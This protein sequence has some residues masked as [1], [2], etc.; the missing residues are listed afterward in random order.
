MDWGKTY[1]DI[2]GVKPDSSS[3]EIKTA[4]RELA[5]AYHPDTTAY[6]S[7]KHAENKFKK[8]N[9]AYE[10]LSDQKKRLE[11]DEQLF[12]RYQDAEADAESVGGNWRR[13][14]L[15]DLPDY[16]GV[17]RPV[18][19]EMYLS[20]DEW[21]N[22]ITKT[23]EIPVI[24]VCP[25]CK[26]TGRTGTRTCQ[27]C[28]GSTTQTKNVSIE[29]NVPSMVRKGIKI[30][31]FG[32]INKNGD[33]GIFPCDLFL[34][35][36]LTRSYETSRS[37]SVNRDYYQE[38]NY[39]YRGNMPAGSDYG[40]HH[41]PTKQ[42]NSGAG[43][44]SKARQDKSVDASQTASKTSAK[45]SVFR[46]LFLLFQALNCIFLLLIF[47]AGLILLTYPPTFV[48]VLI[49][50]LLIGLLLYLNLKTTYVFSK[51]KS[52]R[53]NRMSL[54]I[55]LNF[56]IYVVFFVVT[57]LGGVIL[58]GINLVPLLILN[59]ER[60]THPRKVRIRESEPGGATQ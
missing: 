34:S 41:T 33:V 24:F 32:L 35:V 23:I 47:L 56:I 30:K 52:I 13:I 44:K 38:R 42:E 20:Y 3:D 16:D 49:F 12:R 7:K 14:N 45:K 53:F 48:S 19:Q 1:Y 8:I 59:Y 58:F 9:E 31:G 15:D 37:A 36:N 40:D 39:A 10:V 29:V 54:I 27:N 57:P 55:V 4:Y 50:E 60:L 25:V 46:S 6:K 28:N 18:T 51:G 43:Q 21:L 17:V 2:L 5:K 22:G 11:Y 26:G